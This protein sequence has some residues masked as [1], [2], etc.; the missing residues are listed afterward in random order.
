MIVPLG[1]GRETA[2]GI[3][4]LKFGG[5]SVGTTPARLREVAMR[6]ADAHHAGYPVVVVVSAR[7]ATTDDLVTDANSVA[8]APAAREM[9]QLLATGEIAAAALL[10]ITL[11]DA[12]TPAVSLT[13]AQAGIAAYGHHGDGRIADIDGTRLRE[14]LDSG[15]VAVVAGFQGVDAVGDVLTLGRGGSDTTAVALAASLGATTCEIYTDVDGVYSA[16]PRI[17]VDAQVLTTIG[18]GVMSEMAY[19]GARVLHARSV[20]LAG[21]SGVSIHVRSAFTNKPGTTVVSD[22]TGHE[23]LENSQP[24]TGIAHDTDVAR[25]V[26]HPGGPAGRGAEVF[27]A[28]AEAAVAIDLVA[29]VGDQD[30]GYGWD[31]TIARS[32][33]ETVSRV[34][35]RFGC[36]ADIHESMAKVS[37]V[38]TGLLSHPGT[39][40]R[41]LATLATAGIETYSVATSQVRASVTMSR[42]DCVRA[43]DLLHREFGLDRP[44]VTGDNV[45]PLSRDRDRGLGQAA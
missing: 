9:D 32:Q 41:M 6:I 17:A 16:D 22:Q 35:N 27:A 23:M 21:R 37:L 15:M 39:T 2:A 8:K 11:N 1:P 12:R 7:G 36:E 25:V 43:V 44:A 30:L 3:R 4:V 34:L 13:G 38:G 19:A 33:A 29:R 18:S 14:V 20:D 31:F 5:T 28:L 24:V 45:I 26:V 10:A 42:A 40:G